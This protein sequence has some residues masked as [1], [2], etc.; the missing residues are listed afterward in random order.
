MPSVFDKIIFA[1][2][3][4]EAINLIDK[5]SNLERGIL[6]N[7]K[8]TKNIAYLHSDDTLMPKKINAWSSWNFL[9]NIENQNIFSLTYWMNN[10]QNIDNSD[11][12]FV[13]IYP[14]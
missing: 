1:T 3:A 12:Y 2:H 4:N 11:N 9:Q 7:F 8:Y 5:L 13:S 14:P 6:S 10:L